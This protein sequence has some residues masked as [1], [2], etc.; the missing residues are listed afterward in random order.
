MTD[1]GFQLNKLGGDFFGGSVLITVEK[2]CRRL[3]VKSKIRKPILSRSPQPGCALRSTPCEL[4][5]LCG[6]EGPSLKRSLKPPRSRR[7]LSNALKLRHYSITPSPAPPSVSTV[8]VKQLVWS[9]TPQPLDLRTNTLYLGDLEYIPFRWAKLAL[10]R[11][12][13]GLGLLHVVIPQAQ[14]A[15]H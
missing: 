15:H 7:N 12:K 10:P 3:T 2:P 1:H 8:G 11:T 4:S 5:F 14:S 13:P 6:W 9:D